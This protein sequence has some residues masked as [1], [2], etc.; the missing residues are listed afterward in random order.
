MKQKKR[1]N[2]TTVSTPTSLES[3]VSPKHLKLLCAAPSSEIERKPLK[4]LTSKPL[5][6]GSSHEH[7]PQSTNNKAIPA[8]LGERHLTLQYPSSGSSL[9]SLG[10]QDCSKESRTLVNAPLKKDDIAMKLK[11][12]IEGTT[13]KNSA[14]LPSHAKP[15]KDSLLQHTA[16]F[17]G[18][19]PKNVKGKKSDG[20]RTV[21]HSQKPSVDSTQDNKKSVKLGTMCTARILTPQNEITV[22]Q[23][24]AGS[25]TR[26]THD[27]TD[28]NEIVEEDFTRKMESAGGN[29]LKLIVTNTSGSTLANSNCEKTSGEGIKKNNYCIK[30]DAKPKLNAVKNRVSNIIQR[31]QNRERKLLEMNKKLIEENKNLKKLLATCIS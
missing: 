25:L 6:I 9:A 1:C 2:I 5:Q 17:I 29:K 28:K 23:R 31:Y 26:H 14:K 10:T 20:F 19:E 22:P 15:S 13:L 12:I 7:Y 11:R 4:Q 30:S 27:N 3:L 18:A 24:K 16:T 21:I 8:A